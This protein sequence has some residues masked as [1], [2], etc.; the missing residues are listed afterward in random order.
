MKN[1]VKLGVRDANLLRAIVV[2]CPIVEYP[3]I[4]K[5]VAAHHSR[6]AHDYETCGARLRN[7]HD[8]SR[9]SSQST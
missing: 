9:C 2:T 8:S 7:V 1:L 3:G 6:S 5:R 4:A